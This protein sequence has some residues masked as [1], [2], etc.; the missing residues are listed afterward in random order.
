[1]SDNQAAQQPA[2]TEH[3]YR[4]LSPFWKWLLIIASVLAVFMSAYQVFNLGRFTGFVPIE[5][6]YYYAIV[7]LLLP[8]AFVAFPA[9]EGRGSAGMTWYDFLLVAAMVGVT[10]TLVLYSIEIVDE[11]WEFSAPDFMQYLSL[12]CVILAIEVAQTNFRATFE[13]CNLSWHP[14]FV[15]LCVVA[16]GKR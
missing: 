2:D 14:S 13:T 12:A 1:M 9:F 10:S 4:R 7:A 6:Q 5:N 8:M 16:R 15:R 3:R 11:G